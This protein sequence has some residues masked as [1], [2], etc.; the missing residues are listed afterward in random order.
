MWA[1]IQAF[2]VFVVFNV[3]LLAFEI[4]FQ[5]ASGTILK[6]CSFGR[7]LRGLSAGAV[8]KPDN[9]VTYGNKALQVGLMLLAWI[10]I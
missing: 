10:L 2:M 5:F 8:G 6:E 4:F 1:L 9:F 7:T 3:L